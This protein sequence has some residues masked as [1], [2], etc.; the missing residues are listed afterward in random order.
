MEAQLPVKRHG[1]G[2]TTREQDD[3]VAVECRARYKFRNDIAT[4]AGLGIDNHRTPNEA[5]SAAATIRERESAFTAL[6]L[7]SC[8]TEANSQARC[9]QP[10]DPRSQNLR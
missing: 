10:A 8:V 7:T 1:N 4:C 6:L 2:V 9:G 3:R 5:D